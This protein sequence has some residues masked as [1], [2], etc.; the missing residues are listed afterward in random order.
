MPPI[1]FPY[2]ASLLCLDLVNTNVVL[3]GE[4]VDLLDDFAALV[5]WLRAAG[6][7][8]EEGAR[9]LTASLA[10]TI[11]AEETLRDALRLRAAVRS[12][13]D[14]M[15]AGRSVPDEAVTVVNDVLARR[16]T[17][18]EV[19][20]EG[21]RLRRRSR[22]VAS[23]PSALLGVVADS[24]AE[25]LTLLDPTRVGRCDGAGC[26][27]YFYDTSKNRTRR[28]CSMERCGNRAKVATYRRLRGSPEAR[29][30]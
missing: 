5:E 10:G 4:A 25:L 24:A 15:L 12:I 26:V 20:R 28:W 7:L 30:G 11:E 3:D 23:G 13:A 29:R 19:V 8:D 27:L 2:D 21:E 6:L 9:E 1:A 17:V 16:P 14:R 18:V 22:S